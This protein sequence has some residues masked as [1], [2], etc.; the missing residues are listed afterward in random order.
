MTTGPL[1]LGDNLAL[2]SVNIL[3][4]RCECELVIKS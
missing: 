3:L 4:I 1:L 2:D